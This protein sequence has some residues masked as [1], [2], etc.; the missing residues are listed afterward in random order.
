MPAE[1]IRS[2]AIRYATAG[3][4]A[5][6]QGYG[7]QRHAMGEQS[8]RGG[9]LLAC[10]TGNV[11]ISGG[12]A[13]G[14]ADCTIHRRPHFP[15]LPNPYGRKIPVYLWTDAIVR[16]HEMDELDGVAGTAKAGTHLDSD[17]K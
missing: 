3:P 6:I 17:I 8:A 10:M 13:S 12:W 5:L 15:V 16:G 14:T 11:G 2:L 4:A 1:T 7:A 9:I